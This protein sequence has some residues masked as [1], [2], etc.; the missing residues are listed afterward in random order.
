[1]KPSHKLINISQARK[2]VI[3]L[4]ETD[5]KL[6]EVIKKVGALS[7]KLD[8]L[9]TVFESLGSSILYQQ[10]HGN[11]A[12]KILE[13]LKVLFGSVVDFPKPEQ[14]VAATEDQLMSVGLSRAKAKALKDLADKVSANL[15][16]DRAQ[17]NEMDNLQLTEAFTQVK[18]IGR[19][20]VEMFLIF[21]LGRRDVLPIHDFGVRNG[22]MKV[23]RK[24]RMPTPKELEKYGERWQPFRT[25]AAWYLWR[26]LE[27]P[28]YQT[29]KKLKSQSKKKSK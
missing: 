5:P 21:T 16:P 8:P 24:R 11:A 12:A 20:T 7:I 6:Q 29:K 23:Y 15:I 17:A 3:F 22:F 1:M 18:G 27:L 13:R 25:A 4:S 26:A 9:K 10:L 14:I 2:A 19:W 28:E